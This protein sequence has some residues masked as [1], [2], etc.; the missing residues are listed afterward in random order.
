MIIFLLGHIFL[1][2]LEE[3]SLFFK[4]DMLIEQYKSNVAV[5]VSSRE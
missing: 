3:I 5:V 1:Y 2:L 4:F